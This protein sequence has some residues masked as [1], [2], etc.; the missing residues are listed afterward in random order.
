MPDI[1]VAK[2][3]KN[4][5][6]GVIK[7]TH[8][9]KKGNISNMY[10]TF[11]ENPDDVSFHHQEDDEKIILFLRRH[12]IT[13]VPWILLTII[14]VLLP[15]LLPL[16]AGYLPFPSLPGNFAFVL[17]CIYYLF[18]I[19]FVLFN[20]L[21]WYYNLWIATN[22]RL[23]DI[24]FA[25]LVFHNV[26]ETKYNLIQDVNYSQTGAIRS[27]FNYGDVFAQTAG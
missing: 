24:D 12:F 17:I 16:G 25:D 2:T 3:Q 8:S 1:F 19:S 15:V 13:N 22:K 11:V 9:Q 5:K 21:N 23:I 27:L 14:L 20:F 4:I 26:A 10:S 6:E 18:L 7:E